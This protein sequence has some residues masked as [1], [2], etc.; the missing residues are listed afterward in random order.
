MTAKETTDQPSHPSLLTGLSAFPLTPITDEREDGGATGARASGIDDDA[1]TGL[2]QRLAAANVD[3]IT[4]LGST[5]SYAYLTRAERRHVVELA[6]AAAGA[7]PVLAGI[8]APRT[9]DVLY[10]AQ[11]AQAAGAAGLLLA[12]VTYQP[13]SA[14]EVYQLFHDA[15]AEAAVPLVVYDNPGTT[16]F[17]FTDDLYARVAQ[18]ARV[19]SIK[20]PPI[21]G[22]P[23]SIRTRVAALR[24]CLPSDV[25]IGISGDGVAA[26]A[27]RAGC[28]T[29][30]SVLAGTLP[31]ACQ[32]IVTAAAAGDHQHAQELSNRLMPLWD[33]FSRYGSYRVV[34]A[35]AENL[36]LVKHPNLPRP[37][38]ALDT[39][40]RQQLA[41]AMILMRENGVPGLDRPV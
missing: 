36:G 34:S 17:T 16:H 9:R 11:D 13:L 7:V 40:A 26:D 31:Q 29:W 37:V 38:L 8:G 1:F 2:I 18:L 24:A 33:L 35:L 32:T 23:D 15:A 28:D 14:E 22:G 21:V 41:A 39:D 3:S 25:T 30:Y 27:L 10:H 6:V 4:V 5:G 19:S 12:P 20:I